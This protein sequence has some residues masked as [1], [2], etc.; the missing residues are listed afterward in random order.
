MTKM[1]QLCVSGLTVLAALPLAGF[2]K[3]KMAVQLYAQRVEYSAGMQFAWIYVIFPDGS[4]ARAACSTTIYGQPCV[5][6]PFKA[7]TR[8]S[9]PC[10]DSGHTVQATCLYNELYSADRRGNDLMLYGQNG[11]VAYHI[12]GSWD[13]FV[14]G[15]LPPAKPTFDPNWTAV[16]AD[17][18]FSHSKTKSGT[19]SDHGGVSQWHQP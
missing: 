2:G 5:V 13:T 16:C 1:H 14:V 17:G 11:K 19:C 9:K 3:P 18:T 10:F 8:V 7:E 4:Q 12:D 15:T 6:D